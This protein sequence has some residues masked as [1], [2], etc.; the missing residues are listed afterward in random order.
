VELPEGLTG[1]RLQ[2]LAGTHGT[3]LY[4]TSAETVRARA[5]TVRAAF[6][7]AEI[8]YA[9]KAND[10]PHLLRLL[11]S[12]GARVDAV[13]LGEVT[14]AERAGFGADEIVYTGVFPPEGELAAVARRGLRINVNAEADLERLAGLGPEGEV[15]LRVNP[16]VGAGHHA[17]VVTGGPGAK[18]GVPLDRASDAYARGRE[19]GL[20]V[21]GLHMHIGSGIRDPEPILEGAAALAELVDRLRS[22]GRPVELVD[23]G[24][25]WGVPYRPGETGMDVEGLADG[26]RARLPDDVRLA[27]E[28]GRYLVAESTVLVTRVTAVQPPFVGVD[29]GMNTHLRPALY[30]AHHH[31]SSLEERDA[32]ERTVHV[33]GPVC[34]TADVLGRDRVLPDPRA[35]DLLAV[36][37]VGAYG[38]VMA[39]RYNGRPLPGEVLVEGGEARVVRRPETREDLFRGVPGAEGA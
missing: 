30:D 3:P 10:N 38:R 26:V 23:V 4:V 19:T 31:V 11:R 15:G 25:G 20:S 6:P 7:E 5:R 28:P 14:A 12:E 17:H 21:T 36:H 18:F 2:R 22:E 37:T 32:P 35:G 24:G 39:S 1:D 29:A 13:S 16:L 27:V 33:V 9:A 8:C 34:E